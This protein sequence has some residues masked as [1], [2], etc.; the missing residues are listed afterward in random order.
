MRS[1]KSTVNPPPSLKW[2]VLI[3]PASDYAEVGPNRKSIVYN[4]P[5]LPMIAKHLALVNMRTSIQIFNF[6]AYGY[7]LSK[8]KCYKP[9]YKGN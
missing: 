5:G 8:S 7:T 4:V 1:A 6:I 9:V 2:N 3:F